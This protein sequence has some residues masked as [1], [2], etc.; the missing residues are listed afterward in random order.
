MVGSKNS[1]W[2]ATR[3]WHGRTPRDTLPAMA[4]P[5]F[6]FSVFAGMVPPFSPFLLAILETY[7]IQA[8]HLQ[9]RSVALLA[10]FAYACVDCGVDWHQAIG[11]VLLPPLLPLALWDE[12][13]LGLRL[14]HHHHRN[15][16]RI[17]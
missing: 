3:I 6:L 15:G 7:G 10:V 17:H 13:E 16:G 11:G 4:Q 14:L 2:G 9:P 8:I 1:K 12:P 5:F